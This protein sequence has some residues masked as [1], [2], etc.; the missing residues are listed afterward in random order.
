[1]VIFY[2][3]VMLQYDLIL[4]I[5]GI[6]FVAVNLATLRLVSRWRVDFNLRLMQEHG[7]VNGVAI[8][9]LQSMETLKA[10]GLES[11][12]LRAGLAPMLK[13]PTPSKQWL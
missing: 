3:L 13:P 8:S 10:S 1:M 12:F 6:L 11:D 9:G 4:T 5:V 2:G 7:K